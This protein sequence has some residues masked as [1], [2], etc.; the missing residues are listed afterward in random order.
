V[1]ASVKLVK[2]VCVCV[3]VFSLYF[4]SRYA[5]ER[6]AGQVRESAGEREAGQVRE[7]AGEREA[8]QVRESAGEREAGQV[9]VS[10][11]SVPLWSSVCV[12][13]VA[14]SLDMQASV[15]LVK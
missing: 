8:G 14:F 3:C 1:Q 13:S 6:E 15:K 7:S 11:S 10:V 2:C 9:R 5:G 12:S 4:L